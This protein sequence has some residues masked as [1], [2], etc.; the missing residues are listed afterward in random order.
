MHQHSKH[1]PLGRTILTTVLFGLSAAGCDEAPTTTASNGGVQQAPFHIEVPN[2]TVAVMAIT[3]K[4][5]IEVS[6]VDDEG[7]QV[8]PAECDVDGPNKCSSDFL[9]GATTLEF[10][11]VA[12]QPSVSDDLS[13][14]AGLRSVSSIIKCWFSY[15]V[16][17][18]VYYYKPP[19]TP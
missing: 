16:G 12:E 1:Q 13:R 10:G 14:G 3:K 4:G 19:C 18:K 15:K 7:K 17:N 11:K 5:V 8:K 9:E 2:D 6:A